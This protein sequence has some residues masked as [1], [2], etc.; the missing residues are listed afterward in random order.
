MSIKE[1]MQ[2]NIVDIKIV[3]EKTYRKRKLKS[4]IFVYLSYITLV[5]ALVPLFSLIFEVISQGIPAISLSFLIERIPPMGTPGGGI[6]PAIQGTILIVGISSLI[7]IPIGVISGI[8]IAEFDSTKTN[9]YAALVRFISDVMSNIPSIIAG[10]FGWTFVVLTIGWS[11]IAGA[12]ALSILM[13]PV[14][15]RTTEE[16]LRMVPN[17]IRE[18]ALALGIPKW[19]VITRIILNNAKK[20]ICTGI[21]L[22]IARISGETAPLLLTI[23]GSRYWAWSLTEPTAALPLVIYNFS[24]SPYV[25]IDSPKAWGAAL[26]LITIIMG[27]NLLVRYK[28]IND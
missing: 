11:V 17:E 24:Q 14:I 23:L 19:K 28:T 2:T 20:G 22:S 16:I 9:K 13:I 26:V 7:G 18:A 21:L 10:I 25:A 3:F 1:S 5:I 27:I 4:K 6:G 12:I 15:T 8:Y